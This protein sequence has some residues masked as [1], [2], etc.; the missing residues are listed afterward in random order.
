MRAHLVL[1][2]PG[3]KSILTEASLPTSSTI[4]QSVADE[5]TITAARSLIQKL[6]FR[7]IA[8]S[9]AQITVEAPRK[10]FEQVFGAALT[11]VVPDTSRSATSRPHP[12]TTF[13]WALSPQ[14]PA[15]LSRFVDGVVLPEAISLHE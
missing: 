9:P 12:G 7:I 8:A 5:A 2:A 10:M 4:L 1:K 14:I 15:A 3:G 11:K 6:G 13:R